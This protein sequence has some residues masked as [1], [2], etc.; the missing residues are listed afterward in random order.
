M[1][2]LIGMGVGSAYLFSVRPG[3]GAGI[4]PASA[5]R[6]GMRALISRRVQ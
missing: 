6:K 1:F 5:M 2:T 3:L 4:P